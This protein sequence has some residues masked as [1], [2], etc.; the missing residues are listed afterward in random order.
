LKEPSYRGKKLSEWLS[1]RVWVEGERVELTKDASDAVRAIG[2]NAAPLMVAMLRG[3]DSNLKYSVARFLERHQIRFV[4]IRFK[5]EDHIR[6]MYGFRVL[7]EAS[8]PWHPELAEIALHSEQAWGR[9]ISSL[10]GCDS[11]VIRQFADALHDRDW[12][13]RQRACGALGGLRHHPEISIPVL[14]QALKDSS[15]QVRGRAAGALAMYG[16]TAS[17]AHQDLEALTRDTNSYVSNNVADALR[18][19][20]K[21]D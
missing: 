20:Q 2:T 1:D 11:T 8:R 12:A 6:A 17:S 13:V 14:T 9:A 3:T 19:V 10:A 18:A 5:G 7:G 16:P 15:W 21:P 4:H